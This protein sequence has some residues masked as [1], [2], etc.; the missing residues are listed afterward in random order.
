[1]RQ[2]NEEAKGETK[3]DRSFLFHKLSR[4]M[5]KKQNDRK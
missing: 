3:G 2:R 4:K 5:S 1:M